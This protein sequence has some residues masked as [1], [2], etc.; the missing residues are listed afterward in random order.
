[1][2]FFNARSYAFISF[3]STF[4]PAEGRCALNRFV[5]R[6]SVAVSPDIFPEQQ[7]QIKIG[8]EAVRREPRRS[9][10]FE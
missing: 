5:M 3:P 2:A 4:R 10:E 6:V 9:R 1:M 7:D 8:L